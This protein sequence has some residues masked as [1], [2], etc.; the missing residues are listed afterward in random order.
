MTYAVS[1]EKL[2]KSYGEKKVLNDVSFQ[3]KQGEIFA[4]L[5]VNGAGKTTTLECMEGLKKYDSGRIDI[6]GNFGVQ[7]Q[8]SSFPYNMTA[9]E[10]IKLF[11]LW[12]NTD[13]PHNHILDFGIDKFQTTHYG[14][15]STGQKR[16]LHLTMALLGEPDI[17]F[18]D[19]PTAGLDI[20]GQIHIHN[21]LKELKK[22]GKTIILSSHDMSEIEELC[23]TVAILFQGEVAF[24][25]STLDLNNNQR[26]GFRL[27]VKTSAPIPLK[28]GMTVS[29]ENGYHVFQ[30]ANLENTL[31]EISSICK[32][33]KLS[34]LDIAVENKGIAEK[35]LKVAKGEKE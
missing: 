33:N 21:A 26:N 30:C 5:G 29:H 2:K 17:I 14:K 15:L 8:N 24:C 18:L 27:K 6:N 16:K 28:Q 3:V 35:F 4:L 32:K 11:S 10:T 9:M 34:I 22:R 31:S 19:E 12:K 20:E 25:S 23:D 1:V 13:I 7:L